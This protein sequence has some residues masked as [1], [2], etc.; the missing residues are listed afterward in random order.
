MPTIFHTSV[1]DLDQCF[2]ICASALLAF[3]CHASALATITMA[4]RRFENTKL[5]KFGGVL[6]QFVHL[7]CFGSS[8]L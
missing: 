7:L 6:F 5:Q 3:Q 2:P 1:I 8:G 4:V